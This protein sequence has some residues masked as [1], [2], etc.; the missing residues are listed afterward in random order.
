MPP[1]RWAQIILPSSSMITVPKTLRDL[2]AERKVRPVD[3]ARFIPVSK[4]C[5]SGWVSGR[6]HPTTYHQDRLRLLLHCSTDELTAALAATKAARR[7]GGKS[8]DE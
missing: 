4:T 5:A 2:M 1:F 7:D 6:E 8:H 3:I